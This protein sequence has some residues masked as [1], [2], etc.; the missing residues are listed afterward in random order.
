[1]TRPAEQSATK[2]WTGAA[3]GACGLAVVS[4]LARDGDFSLDARRS[5]LFVLADDQD[6]ASLRQVF[7]E[8]EQ[9]ATDCGITEVVMRVSL[10]GGTYA[11]S[12]KARR[13]EA[14][15]EL[16]PGV[17]VHWVNNQSLEP[18]SE[19]RSHEL[20]GLPSDITGKERSLLAAAMSAARLAYALAC[21]SVKVVEGCVR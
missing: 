15:L 4:L 2:A 13:I 14:A 18:W 9:F 19:R 7:E 11:T 17:A 8:L 6:Q 20:P 1:M 12:R 21:E 3:A 5:A 10:R 16:L